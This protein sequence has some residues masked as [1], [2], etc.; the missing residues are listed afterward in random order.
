MRQRNDNYHA[1]DDML[2]GVRIRQSVDSPVNLIQTRP[3]V[4]GRRCGTL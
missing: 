2:P 4:S 3:E 1:A